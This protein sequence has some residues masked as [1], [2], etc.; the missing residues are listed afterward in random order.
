M[1]ITP[2]E[3]R[4]KTF[5]KVFRGY[6][7]EDVN[8]FMESLSQV[9]DLTLAENRE[10]RIRLENAEK[11]VQKLREVEDS[12]F[13][14]LK[15]AED[16][17]ASM[18]DQA[19]KKAN[20]QVREAE[21]EAEALIKE[22]KWRAKTLLEEAE[23]EAKKTYNNLQKELKSLEREHT[24]L[25]NDRE[26]VLSHL[27]EIATEVL[28]KVNKFSSRAKANFQASAPPHRAESQRQTEEHA[29]SRNAKIVEAKEEHR[30]PEKVRAQE[31]EQE[32]ARNKQE[33]D[34]SSSFF[35]QL[36]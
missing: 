34:S 24:T 10:L 29:V 35:D 13:K 9:W 36:G 28:E 1:K 3:I 15:T 25:E 21:I 31:A 32:P 17:S 14:T 4:Q 5:E 7:I 33:D 19:T 22:A 18:L 16:T 12:L 23:D 2:I 6:N 11:E 20:L 30:Q 27:R 8:A 26:Q